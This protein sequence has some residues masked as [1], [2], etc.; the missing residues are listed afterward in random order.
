MALE[1]DV[2]LTL[3]LPDT[4]PTWFVSALT[5]VLA[6]L[7]QKLE[8]SIVSP[9]DA[10]ISNLTASVNNLSGRVDTDI[11]GLAVVI[12][13][14]QTTVNAIGTETPAQSAALAD[15]RARIDQI[16]SVGSSP[17]SPKTP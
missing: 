13:A 7:L 6:P 17:V 3:I 8:S 12:Q 11:G 15:L 9:I 4:P 5:S 16:D 10:Q 14:L 1:L 2:K